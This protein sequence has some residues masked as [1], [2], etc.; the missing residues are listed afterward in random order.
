MPEKQDLNPPSW[1]SVCNYATLQPPVGALVQL[2]RNSARLSLH[3]ASDWTKAKMCL[4][5]KDE[6]IH[7]VSQRAFGTVNVN[8]LLMLDLDRAA[9]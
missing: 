4:L 3:A 6:R 7:P 2:S 5:N 9:F 8:Y 1:A